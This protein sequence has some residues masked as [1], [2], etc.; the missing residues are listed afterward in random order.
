MPWTSYSY[1][2]FLGN[3]TLMGKLLKCVEENSRLE[4][5]GM[6]E[7]A[8]K[9]FLYNKQINLNKNPGHG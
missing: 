9:I 7:N 8:I 6:I 3:H 1:L 4:A 5:Q 2:P